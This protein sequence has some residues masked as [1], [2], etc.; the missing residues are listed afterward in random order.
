MGL[1]YGR[2]KNREGI[3]LITRCNRKEPLKPWNVQIF[4]KPWRFHKGT[5]P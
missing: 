4:D 3:K 2:Q 1:K 5:I